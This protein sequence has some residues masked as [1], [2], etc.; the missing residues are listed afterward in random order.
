MMKNNNKKCKPK[1]FS[2]NPKD[3]NELDP[4]LYEEIET[5]KNCTVHIYKCKRCG[6]IEI[7]WER[8]TEE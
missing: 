4:C 2:Y 1:L 8:G 5:V 3:G 7:M 6:N